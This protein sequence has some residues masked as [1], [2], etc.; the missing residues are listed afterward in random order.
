MERRTLVKFGVT[1]SLATAACCATPL[2]PILLA[3]LGLSAWTAW[4]DRA[5]IPAF[6][7]FAILTLYAMT[8]QRE[9]TVCRAAGADAESCRPGGQ[10]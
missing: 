4:V 6:L 10:P 9:A 7:I 8:R 5:L 1:G 3:A 2:L